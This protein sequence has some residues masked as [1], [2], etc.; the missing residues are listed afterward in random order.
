MRVI[1]FPS[2]LF[3]STTFILVYDTTDINLMNHSQ[4]HPYGFLYATDTFGSPFRTLHN[5]W[6]CNLEGDREITY[7]YIT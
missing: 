3:K 7:M 6:R 2:F 1:N 4:N 5:N